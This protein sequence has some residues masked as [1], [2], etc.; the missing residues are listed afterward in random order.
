[1]NDDRETRD[2]V[3]DA[4]ERLFG[5]RGFKHVTVREICRSAGA[6][7]AAVNYHFGDKLGLYREVLQGAIDAMRATTEL[8]RAAGEG[9]PAEEQLRQFISI[10]LHRVLAPGS[11][12]I[13]R[14]IHREQ[15]DPTPAL[16]ALVEQ[17]LRPRIE[18]VSDIVARMM[19]CDPDDEAVLRAVASIQAQATSYL[20]HPI[21]ARL[22]FAFKPTRARIDEAARHV[23][24]FSIAGVHAIGRTAAVRSHARRRSG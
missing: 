13:H 19:G 14:L 11:E 8:A 7:V 24:T 5:E 1:M 15:H 16:D 21:A 22:G 6:N 10:F 4:A 12:R 3:L 9:R 23:A 18:Y 2:R 17:G 20:P